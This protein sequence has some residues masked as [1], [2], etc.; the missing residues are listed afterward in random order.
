MEPN[1]SGEVFCFVLDQHHV[2][3]IN[4][5]L[6]ATWGHCLDE[7]G[8]QHDYYGTEKVLEDL[9]QCAGRNE[10]FVEVEG[11]IRKHIT[12]KIIGKV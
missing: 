2:A 5:V 7:P 6:C 3:L 1:P 12:Q 9:A 8:V 4:D 11:S 10:G